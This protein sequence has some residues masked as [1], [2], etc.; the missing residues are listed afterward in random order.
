[1]PPPCICL[2]QPRLLFPYDDYR[3][4][5]GSVAIICSGICVEVLC[6]FCCFLWAVV[7]VHRGAPQEHWAFLPL[8]IQTFDFFVMSFGLWRFFRSYYW[9]LPSEKRLRVLLLSGSFFRFCLSCLFSLYVLEKVPLVS[10]LAVCAVSYSVSTAL[11]LSRKDAYTWVR[12]QC[13]DLVIL[14][15]LLTLCLPAAASPF[16]SLPYPILAS[17]ACIWPLWV[18]A[19]VHLC[20]CMMLGLMLL[21]DALLQQNAVTRVLVHVLEVQAVTFL[22][23]IVSLSQWL[24]GHSSTRFIVFISSGVVSFFLFLIVAAFASICLIA[25]HSTAL[26]DDVEQG[27]GD[28]GAPGSPLAAS[29]VSAAAAAAAMGPPLMCDMKVTLERVSEHFYKIRG[30]VEPPLMDATAEGPPTDGPLIKGAD[31]KRTAVKAP[32]VQSGRE[33]Q[34]EQQAGVAARA[35]AAADAT[36]AAAAG[37]GT[38]TIAAATDPAAATNTAAPSASEDGASQAD[39]GL[40]MICCTSAAG[41][42]LMYCGHGGLCFKCAQKC[43]HR[44]GLCPT[45]RRPVKGVVE[46][47]PPSD[48]DE[49]RQ[50]E[51]VEGVV[52]NVSS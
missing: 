34:R 24:S 35:P 28:Q 26:H 29:S 12:L 30:P 17:P 49:L 11:N 1:M 23:S 15:E 41:A 16:L 43:F 4:P 48:I 51:R 46:V 14:L 9:L 31:A 27:E 32:S 3:G 10:L 6:L 5:L 7:C 13:W 33:K 42:V 37:T 38:A 39:V 20:C 25:R 47:Q 36:T 50:K 44:T 22:L 2:F 18:L 21:R 52:R 19:G 8:P 40:C 45:C